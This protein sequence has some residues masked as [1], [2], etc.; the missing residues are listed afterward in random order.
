[1]TSS[2]EYDEGVLK[3][4][5]NSTRRRIMSQIATN[6]SATYSQIMQ[7]LGLDPSLESG[8]FNYHLKELTEVGLI[9]RIDTEY[10]I[11]DLGK[12]ALILV[13][14]VRRE[15]QVDRYGVLSAAI[16][17]SPMEE[18]HLFRSQMGVSFGFVFTLFSPVLMLL[19]SDPSRLD[20]LMAVV[21]FSVSIITLFAS[22][23]SLVRF[24]RKYDLGLSVLLLIGPDWFLVRSPN[25]GSYLA[26]G[27]IAGINLGSVLVYLIL[28]YSR[29]IPVFLGPG[30][31]L[32]A[33]M[34]FTA[35][36]AFGIAEE[37]I[38]KARE[39]EAIDGEQ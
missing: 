6:G 34:M 24:A 7:V 36:I 21:L 3:A 18:I 28:V 2:R 32:F 14:Q 26:L 23:L 1:M 8:T 27:A 22:S 30:I 19:S 4:L 38:R 15:P 31:V 9:E 12:R 33:I 39:L 11:T 29:S 10:R 17:M 35:P 25:R 16:S 37:A 5:S 13:D 20:L